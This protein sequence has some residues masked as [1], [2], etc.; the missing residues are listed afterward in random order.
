MT[1]SPDQMQRASLRGLLALASF[2]VAFLV[3]SGGCGGSLSRVEGIVT[4]DGQ[5]LSNAM[6][7]FFP[8]GP[9]GRTAAAQADESGR[10]RLVVSPHRLRVVISAPKVVGQAKDGDGMADVLKERVPS[11]YSDMA[12]NELVVEPVAGIVTA[13]DF[14]L[15]SG[16]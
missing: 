4:L 15:V 6:L 13:A 9:E 3:A 8:M 12:S 1:R 5:P 11:R 7:M 16:K 14:A 10:Y 2:A